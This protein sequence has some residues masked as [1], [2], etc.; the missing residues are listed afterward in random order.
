MLRESQAAVEVIPC[1]DAS[2]GG[3]MLTHVPDVLHA[4]L[5]AV[6]RSVIM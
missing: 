5:T 1:A 4:E 2:E 6:S 3:L